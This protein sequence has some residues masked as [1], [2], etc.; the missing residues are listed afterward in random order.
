MSY[1]YSEESRSRRTWDADEDFDEPEYRGRPAG[2][3]HAGLGIASFILGL[4]A[5]V[6]LVI[7]VLLIIAAVNQR[8]WGHD[9][10]LD[11]LIGLTVCGSGV[12]TMV[13]T[14]LGIGG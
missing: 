14:G 4:A 2:L 1:D 13:G 8:P 9:E 10:A 12:L 3:P 5:I 11:A 6:V 7:M